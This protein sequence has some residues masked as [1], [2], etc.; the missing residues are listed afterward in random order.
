[1]PLHGP[2][3]YQPQGKKLLGWLGRHWL[4]RIPRSRC[5][6]GIRALGRLALIDNADDVMT[7]L[8]QAVRQ[9][10]SVIEE[11]T[12]RE[13]F[14]VL[15]IA[16]IS[17]GTG[18]GCLADVG[19]AI[20][21]ILREEGLERVSVVSVLILA[22]NVTKERKEL[23]QA[24]AYVTLS[25]LHSFLDSN[26]RFPGVKALGLSPTEGQAPLFDEVI[27]AD[28]GDLAVETDLDAGVT[29]S[30]RVSLSPAGHSLRAAH[31]HDGEPSPRKPVTPLGSGVFAWP[32]WVSLDPSSSA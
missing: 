8:R 18:G 9:V 27:L 29:P 1:M 5:V 14:Q 10:G 12:E 28:F 6:E 32:V 22:S 4:F 3:H 2:D 13:R 23:A 19:F 24:N 30:G 31:G 26:C 25:E 16:S 17:G 20:R 15:V 7:R 21:R 11:E